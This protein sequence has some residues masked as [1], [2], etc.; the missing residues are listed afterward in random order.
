MIQKWG[1]F[2]PYRH[3]PMKQIELESEHKAKEMPSPPRQVV[4]AKKR[5]WYAVNGVRYLGPFTT[6]QAAEN[7]AR[8]KFRF[9]NFVGR[10]SGTVEFL[11]PDAKIP[12]FGLIGP[13]KPK[14]S[15]GST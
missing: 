10:R 5:A 2:G 1:Q 6:K 4:R 11:D 13:L 7:A 15:L 14:Y 12:T 3:D 9:F 8:A